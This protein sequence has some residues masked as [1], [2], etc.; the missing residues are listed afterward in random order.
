MRRLPKEPAEQTSAALVLLFRS[1]I[2]SL[3]A[4]SL[5]TIL[6]QLIVIEQ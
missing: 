4:L 2:L 3:L 6:L 5:F 1:V